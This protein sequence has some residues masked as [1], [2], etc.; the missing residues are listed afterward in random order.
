MTNHE[1]FVYLCRRAKQQLSFF[2]ALFALGDKSE[3]E[4]EYRCS[5][6]GVDNFINAARVVSDHC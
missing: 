4:R 6:L 2:D 5:F 1:L 3:T